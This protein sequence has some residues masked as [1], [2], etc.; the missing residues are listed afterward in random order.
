MWC[1]RCAGQD[2]PHLV[3]SAR[4]L[5]TV[6]LV[7]ALHLDGGGFLVGLTELWLSF[8]PSAS[9]SSGRSQTSPLHLLKMLGSLHLLSS[10]CFRASSAANRQSNIPR[11]AAGGPHGQASAHAH[12]G[13]GDGLTVSLG[14]G[15]LLAIASPP[16]RERNWERSCRPCSRKTSLFSVVCLGFSLSFEGKK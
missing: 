16:S 4:P 12:S 10:C 3:T 1:F 14:T 7:T 5:Q 8:S 9:A 15:K 2:S 13:L 6:G 11:A